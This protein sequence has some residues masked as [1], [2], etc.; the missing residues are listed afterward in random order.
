MELEKQQ[1]INPDENIVNSIEYRGLE[2]S[3]CLYDVLCIPLE[4]P[5]IVCIVVS[6]CNL[7]NLC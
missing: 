4:S 7:Y 2:V 5:F 6:T 3:V 1:P